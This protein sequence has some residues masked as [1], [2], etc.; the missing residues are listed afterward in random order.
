MTVEATVICIRKINKMPQK[1]YAAPMGT[2]IDLWHRD[3]Q[4]CLGIWPEKGL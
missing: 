2:L 3:G 1:T 4:Q